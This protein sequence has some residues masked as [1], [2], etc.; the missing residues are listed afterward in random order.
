MQIYVLILALMIVGAEDIALG[1]IKMSTDGGGRWF[2]IGLLFYLLVAVF[3]RTALLT[4]GIGYINTIWSALSV[5]T[6]IL[7][8]F[9]W[10]GETLTGVQLLAASLATVAAVLLSVEEQQVK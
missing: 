7:V 9:L 8:G 10:F 5:P 3:L 6:S 1:G 4:E 2:F